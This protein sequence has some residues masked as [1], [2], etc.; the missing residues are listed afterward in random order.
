MSGQVAVSEPQPTV[1]R[2]AS[3]RRTPSDAS[4][5][6]RWCVHETLP[7]LSKSTSP[8]CSCMGVPVYDTTIG[9]ARAHPP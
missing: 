6:T 8:Y 1:P 3:P 4:K 9:P 2:K 5:V 7:S